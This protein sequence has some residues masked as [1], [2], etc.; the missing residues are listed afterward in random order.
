MLSWHVQ[1][2]SVCPSVHSVYETGQKDERKIV[3][4]LVDRV[5][6]NSKYNKN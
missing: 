3:A 4:Y 1:P 2:F 5:I 6:Q